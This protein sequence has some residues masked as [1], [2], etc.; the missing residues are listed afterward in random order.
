MLKRTSKSTMRNVIPIA[1]A[2]RY[3]S[4]EDAPL[5]GEE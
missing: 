5:E 1:E 2:D 3:C 4:E